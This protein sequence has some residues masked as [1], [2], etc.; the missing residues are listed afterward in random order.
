[1]TIHAGVRFFI[2][3]YAGIEYDLNTSEQAAFGGMKYAL[4]EYPEINNIFSIKRI[5]MLN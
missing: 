5:N 1:M 2:Q 3:L 4:H